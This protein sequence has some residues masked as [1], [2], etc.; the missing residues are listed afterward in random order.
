MIPG[1]ERLPLHHVDRLGQ[2]DAGLDASTG[3]TFFLEL[4]ERAPLLRLDH[5]NGSHDPNLAL[6]PSRASEHGESV[7]V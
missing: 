2:D 1:T 4:G 5:L 7:A 3:N 6:V